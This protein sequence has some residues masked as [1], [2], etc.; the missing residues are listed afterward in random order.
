[1]KMVLYQCGL[2]PPKPVPQSDH[3]MGG[4]VYNISKEHSSTLSKSSKS[5][6]IKKKSRKV[7]NSQPTE[8]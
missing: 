5:R 6:K 3:E 4:A 7:R 8:A 1:M 2:P